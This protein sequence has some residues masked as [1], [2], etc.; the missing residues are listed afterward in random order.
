MRDEIKHIQQSENNTQ[1]KI[2][3]KKRSSLEIGIKF[4]NIP[5]VSR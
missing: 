1:L 3:K 2:V 5:T 4:D